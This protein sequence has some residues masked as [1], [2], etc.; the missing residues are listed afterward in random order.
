MILQ[1]VE[2]YIFLL[3]FEWTLQQCITNTLPVINWQQ[4]QSKLTFARRGYACQ[5]DSTFL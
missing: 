5:Y 4:V 2:C 3:I 1:G